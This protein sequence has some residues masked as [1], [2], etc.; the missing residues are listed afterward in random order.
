M[1]VQNCSPVALAPCPDYRESACRA[2]IAEIAEKCPVLHDI[3]AGTKVAVKVNLITLMKP[4]K[5]GTTH[6]ALLTALVEYLH[7]QGA[8]VVIGDSP[9]GTYN[10]AYLEGVYRATGMTDAAKAGAELNWDFTV[11]TAQFPKA[12]AAKEFE[13]TA[14]LDNADLIINFC[15]LKTHG[16]MTMS[17]AVKNMFGTIPGLTK[18]A[19]HYRF[20]DYAS[21]ADMLID[22]NEYFQPALNIVDAVIGM[23]GNG[24]T[25]GT[26]RQVG[27]VL[28]SESPYA[29]DLVCAKLIGLTAKDIPTLSAAAARGLAP[30]SAEE[31]TVLGDIAPFLIPDYKTAAVEQEMELFVSMDNAFGRFANSA[32]KRILAVRPMLKSDQCVGCGKCAGLCPAHAITM[33]RGKPKIERKTCI[34]CFCCQE[35]CP[36]GALEARRSRLGNMILKKK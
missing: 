23:E 6:P 36:A 8:E 17:C 19:Y 28:A 9:G 18:P 30:E 3:K 15:K 25:A 12:A 16:M 27:A 22:L 34:R 4:E 5:A 13:Y 35:F 29:L 21:F 24:P 7:A 14:Y 2:A 11:K 32:V 31:I 26:P 1:S 33:Q 20:P 10:K